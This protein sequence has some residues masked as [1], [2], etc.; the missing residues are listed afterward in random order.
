MGDQDA[1]GRAEPGLA[2]R[3]SCLGLGERAWDQRLESGPGT[4]SMNDSLVLV[5]IVFAQATVKAG[6]DEQ[7]SGRAGRRSHVVKVS[8]VVECC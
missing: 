8:S 2:Y 7:R 5:G 4:L 1:G 6:G 3:D